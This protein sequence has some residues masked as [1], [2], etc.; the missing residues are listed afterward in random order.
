MDEGGIVKIY[1]ATPYSHKDPA[2]RE[3]RFN[4]INRVAARL[5]KEGHVVF[6]PISHSHHI[7]IAGDTPMGFDFWE[8][9]DESFIDWCDVMF[10]YKAPG[11]ED[12]IG[13]GAEID[14]ALNA[15]KPV[16]FIK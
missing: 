1:L 13:V 15:G 6:S 3:S 16:Q 2:V 9:Q 12:S 4:A 5:M 8:S 10:V 11:W 7:A 14:M